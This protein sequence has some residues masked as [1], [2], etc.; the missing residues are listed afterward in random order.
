MINI[1]Q[2]SEKFLIR[3][4]PKA[5]LFDIFIV[6]RGLNIIKYDLLEEKWIDV[7][8]KDGEKKSFGLRETFRNARDIKEL[9]IVSDPT[10]C[11]MDEVCV[12]SFLFA[13][14]REF[15]HLSKKR[16]LSRLEDP[17]G[18]FDM[19]AFEEYIQMTKAEGVSYDLFDGERPFMQMRRSEINKLRAD[20]G[21]EGPKAKPLGEDKLSKAVSELSATHPTGNNCVFFYHNDGIRDNKKT[22]QYDIVLSP[23]QYFRSLLRQY[24]SENCGGSG[25]YP[26]LF[27]MQKLLCILTFGKDLFETIILNTPSVDNPDDETVLPLWRRDKLVYPLRGNGPGTSFTS[28]IFNAPNIFHY[29][30]FDED[31]NVKTIYK[32]GTGTG[33]SDEDGTT[34]AVLRKQEWNKIP[35]FIVKTKENKNGITESLMEASQ[36][37]ASFYDLSM[38]LTGLTDKDAHY[39]AFGM[40]VLSSWIGR[41]EKDSVVFTVYCQET[42][43][44]SYVFQKKSTLVFPRAIFTGEKERRY[45]E[46]YI[47]GI[48]NFGNA[49]LFYSVL[50]AVG[51]SKEK[52]DKT[53]SNEPQKKRIAAAIEIMK[54]QFYSMEKISFFASIDQIPDVSSVDPKTGN[55]TEILEKW[56]NKQ[57][58]RC[59]REA[60]DV[61][62]KN[63]DVLRVDPVEKAIGL[64]K[65]RFYKE[66]SS[67]QTDIKKG[68]SDE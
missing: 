37:S 26:S 49:K 67:G 27:G 59:E 21:I 3:K 66:K 41:K 29:G 16:L 38:T 63:I 40:T 19:D 57:M 30:A 51:I 55:E 64:S 25:F 45:Y 39:N 33:R 5:L 68:G 9:D 52:Y 50:A 22:V 42:D 1:D 46:K 43:K 7:I 13:F 58:L 53:K 35:Y 61:F 8:M 15:E 60:R 36:S 18:R 2:L 20:N 65:I 47:K 48:K 14:F 54:E 44:A 32:P 34:V 12:Y 11:Y 17:A 10:A 28:E 4:F 56:Y 24:F 31:G 23:K 6:E 62:L